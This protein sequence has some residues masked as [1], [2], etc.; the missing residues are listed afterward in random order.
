VPFLS[1]SVRLLTWLGAL[2][3]LVIPFA[4][5]GG[6][7]GLVHVAMQQPSLTITGSI[8]GLTAGVPASLAL[9]LNSSSDA[10]VEVHRL[11][12]RVTGVSGGCPETALVITAWAGRLVVPQHG[13]AVVTLPVRVTSTHCAGATWQLAYTSS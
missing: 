10:G 12:A 3:V 5:P 9:T 7:L 1:A 13:S 8:E 11:A 2:A 6:P 4:S